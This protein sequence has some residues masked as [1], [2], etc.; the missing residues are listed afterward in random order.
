MTSA[1]KIITFI[2]EKGGVGKT[3]ICFNIAWELSR[4]AKR[5]LMIDMDG[6]K[7]NL[8]F[9]TGVCTGANAGGNKNDAPNGDILTNKDNTENHDEFQDKHREILTMSDVFKRDV[10]IKLTIM[11]VKENLDIVPADSGVANL[12]MSAKVSKFRKAVESIQKL[13]DYVFIDVNP[14]PG[15]SHYLSLSI[16]DYAVIVMLP[17]IASLEGNKGILETVEEIQETNNEH[18]EILG[19]VLNKN[20]DRTVLSRQVSTVTTKMAEQHKTKIFATKIRNSVVMSE[21]IISHKGVTDYASSSAVAEDI[22]SLVDEFVSRIE[23][24]QED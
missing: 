9:F 22:R 13:Y 8:T 4:Q 20:N 21:N 12:D 15:W 10:D 11:S 24:R 5:I 19:I 7:A 23:Q 2:N 16:C 3:S 6:Q 1:A 18:L 17:D 14:A